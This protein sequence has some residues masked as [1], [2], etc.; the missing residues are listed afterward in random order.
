MRTE[1]EKR[2]QIAQ[3]QYTPP[4]NLTR[5]QYGGDDPAAALEQTELVPEPS[6]A[7]LAHALGRILV[8]LLDGRD[9]RR[10][11]ERVVILCYK[12]RPDLIGAPSIREIARN[13]GI[14]KSYVGK[15]A[16]QFTRIFGIRGI[17]TH[18]RR[19]VPRERKFGYGGGSTPESLPGVI[20]RF[21]EWRA[22][23]DEAEGAVP[24]DRAQARRMLQELAPVRSFLEELEARAE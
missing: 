12:L 19:T 10:I 5:G 24:A 14:K 3:G 18:V 21:M 9:L 13:R 8:W 16:Q 15:L 7:E 4:R 20:N 22:F 6:H 23:M 17:N 11:G 1:D 2:R